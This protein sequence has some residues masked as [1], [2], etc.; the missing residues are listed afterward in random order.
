MVEASQNNF[1][2]YVIC[3]KSLA[4]LSLRQRDQTI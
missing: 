4:S 1:V 2:I 3:L